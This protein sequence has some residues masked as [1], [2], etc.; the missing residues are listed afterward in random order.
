MDRS[1]CS[2]MPGKSQ[3]WTAT[4]VSWSTLLIL[5]ART[6]L[7]KPLVAPF[8]RQGTTQQRPKLSWECMV[9]L[10]HHLGFSCIKIRA[11][12]NWHPFGDS[13]DPGRHV[14]CAAHTWGVTNRVTSQTVFKPHPRMQQQWL[15]FSPRTWIWV[16]I[17][18]KNAF[19]LLEW[20][21]QGLL[22]SQTTMY[23]GSMHE[24]WSPSAFL[25]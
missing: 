8:Y 17:C 12:R 23:F 13:C 1:N 7:Y 2:Q 4:I 11:G 10:P 22:I 25:P 14:V 21:F 3:G 5:A 19:S 15:V 18:K 9:Y 6:S 24:L 16:L 20:T